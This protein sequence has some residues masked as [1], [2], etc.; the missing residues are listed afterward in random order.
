MAQAWQQVTMKK[1][2]LYATVDMALARADNRHVLVCFR[3]WDEL[4]MQAQENSSKASLPF[5]TE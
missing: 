4:L 1:E 2:F 5:P 3:A